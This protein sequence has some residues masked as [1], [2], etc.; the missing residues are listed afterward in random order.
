[1][2]GPPAGN[3]LRSVRCEVYGRRRAAHALAVTPARDGTADPAQSTT[4]QDY[5]A[6]PS[7]SPQV[8]GP[9]PWGRWRDRDRNSAG[10]PEH[11]RHGEQ[12]A[13]SAGGGGRTHDRRVDR[14]PIG[15]GGLQGGGGPRRP[16]RRR[17]LPHLAAGPR[18]PRHHAARLRRTG[19][20]P[21]DPGPAPGAGPDA[22]RAGRR[23]GP[24]GRP[25]RR[26]RRL[27]DQALLHART[28]RPG[29]C[30]AAPRRACPAGRPD[31]RAGQPALRRAGDRPCAAPG[32]AGLGRRPP[33]ADRVRPARLPGR[34]AARRAHP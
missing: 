2:S 20:V 26:C 12:P 7:P 31:A 29:Q 16:R 30:A 34:P 23:D 3:H 33:D 11:R 27:H 32:P 14:G 24:A 9:Q 22:H 18:R 25:R 28:G 1:M 13:Q 19:G 5:E 8:A 10:Q 15:R 21:P 6:E 17:R 4:E